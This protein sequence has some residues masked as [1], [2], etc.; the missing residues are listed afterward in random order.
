MQVQI[1]LA[2]LTKVVA[3]VDKFIYFGNECPT[4]KKNA[5]YVEMQR[6]RGLCRYCQKPHEPGHT[7]CREHLKKTRDRVNGIRARATEN[8]LCIHCRLPV[9]PGFKMCN[10]N[11]CIPSRRLTL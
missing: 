6:I 4:M 2:H 9:D 5:R 1:L 8:G 3:V 10:R 7:M 11:E